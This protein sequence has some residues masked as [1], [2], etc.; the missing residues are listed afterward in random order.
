MEMSF[1][2]KL[3]ELE[4]IVEKLENGQLSL[5]ESLL[6]FENGIKLVKECNT[7]LTNARQK[8][9]KLIEENDELGIEPLE[10]QGESTQE[11]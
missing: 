2:E 9:E 5:D 1:E 8:V 7:L 3:L 6:I 4:N 10:L 11:K